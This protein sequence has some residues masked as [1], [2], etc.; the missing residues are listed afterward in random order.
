MLRPF[1]LWL[2]VG[3]LEEEPQSCGA[4]GG[5]G[6]CGFDDGTGTYESK[7]TGR[8]AGKVPL[9]GDWCG[10][11]DLDPNAPCAI[12]K[13]KMACSGEYWCTTTC[14]LW[15]VSILSAQAAVTCEQFIRTS[16]FPSGGE[17]CRDDCLLAEI[18]P[19]RYPAPTGLGFLCAPGTC[20]P[21]VQSRYKTF[22][23]GLGLGVLECPCNWFGSDCDNDWV[24]IQ[25]VIRKEILGDFMIIVF[26]VD[27]AGWH[28]VMRDHRPGGVVRLQRPSSSAW[29]NRLV[30]QPYALAN[31]KESGVVGELEVLAGKPEAEYFQTVTEVA[32]HVRSLP[33]G[34]L[35]I[36][37]YINP[38]IAGFF[39]KKHAFLMD[40]LDDSITDVIMVATGAGLSGVRTAIASLLQRPKMRVHL[41]Y[42]LR[43]ARQL[44]YRQLIKGWTSSM[45]F[46]LLVS[47][48]ESA[49]R[50]GPEEGI[51]A[52]IARGQ[53]LKKLAGRMQSSMSLPASRKF[54]VQHA[55]GLD[56]AEGSLKD[57]GT[58]LLNSIVVICGRSELLLDT[59]QI[60]QAACALPN[61][62]GLLKER[63]FM[64]I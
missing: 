18:K 49:A 3:A 60:L 32:R 8:G 24:R 10:S 61:C 22:K 26:K 38:S 41:Y 12:D 43:D 6:K 20:D 2:L 36:P 45:T 33:E 52:A 5:Q 14:S 46:T 25:A 30:E 55:L 16:A 13:K 37:L 59:E 40:A 63:I 54:Y 58:S 9:C 34:P 27:E 1:H 42:G 31:D 23:A 48:S 28:L 53:A 50:Q 64:N 44:P 19:T 17:V 51:Q 57:R 4:K 7:E 62:S 21:A 35:E 39:N 56:L 29:G 11:Q 47:S 15:N